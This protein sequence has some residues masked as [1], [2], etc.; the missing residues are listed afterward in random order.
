MGRERQQKVWA[1]KKVAWKAELKKPV[2]KSVEEKF[3]V[4]RSSPPYQMLQRGQQNREYL[5]DPQWKEH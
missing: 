5:S 2:Q 3:Q 4:W 1:G